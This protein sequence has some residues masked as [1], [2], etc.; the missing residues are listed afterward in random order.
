LWNISGRAPRRRE[1][2]K[3]YFPLRLFSI[4]S[5]IFAATSGPLNRAM[6]RIPVGEVT[7]FSVRLPSM[8]SM[9]T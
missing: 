3:V 2:K 1:T 8:T 9:P 4:R 7:L 6:A 5:Q